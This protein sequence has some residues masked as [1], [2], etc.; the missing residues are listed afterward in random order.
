MSPSPVRQVIDAF[1][2]EMWNAHDL[3]KFERFVA[4]DVTFR[5]LRGP[6][7]DYEGYREMARE[8]MEAMPD[9]RFDI[10]EAVEQ[11]SLIAMRIRLRGTHRATWRGLGPTGCGIDVAGRPWARVRD[12]K[13][14]EFWASFDELGLL[15]QLGHVGPALLGPPTK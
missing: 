15:H 6:P 8:F 1:F 12:G 10:E 2:E 9:L 3:S 4:R 13:V 14:V 7:K 5:P 11:G